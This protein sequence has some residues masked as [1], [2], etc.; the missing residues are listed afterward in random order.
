[1]NHLIELQNNDCRRSE[2]KNESDCTRIRFWQDPEQYYCEKLS[3]IA[4]S[5]YNNSI[6]YGLLPF[7][8][9]VCK[10]NKVGFPISFLQIHNVMT[11][12]TTTYIKYCTSV[13][14]NTV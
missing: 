7:W 13:H 14:F 5:K 12:K 1:M 11:K 4:E 3:P 6:A 10:L 9:H 2:I 8:E